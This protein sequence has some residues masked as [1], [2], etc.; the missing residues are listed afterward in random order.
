MGNIT[1]E[2]NSA[3]TEIDYGYNNRNLIE[4]ITNGRKQ[5]KTKSYD[6]AGKPSEINAP[7]GKTSY[8]YDGNGNVLTVTD[9]ERINNYFPLLLHE[10]AG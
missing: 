10:N 9:K 4:K 3:G 6:A 5:E 8:T 1:S 7:E 2:K